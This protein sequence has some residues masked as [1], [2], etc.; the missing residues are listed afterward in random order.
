MAAI[1]VVVGGGKDDDNGNSSN[2]IGD[3]LL[4][5]WCIVVLSCC[6]VGVFLC[7]CIIVLVY[8][9]MYIP[10]L[11]KYLVV[12]VLLCCYVVGCAPPTADTARTS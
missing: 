3:D 12:V 6:H 5:C 11:P 7:W 8:C 4:S 9:R 1:V 2:G 10:D